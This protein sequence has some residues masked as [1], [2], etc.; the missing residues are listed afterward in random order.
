MDINSL[1]IGE[2]K[3]LAALFGNS[4]TKQEV[5]LYARYVGKYVICRSRNEGV[6]AGTV[7]AADETGVI[8]K[9]ARRLYY[10][11]PVNKNVSWYE[12]VANFG[13]DSSSKVGSAV[14]KVIVED[15]SLTVCSEEAEKSIRGAKEHAQ[16]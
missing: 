1:T 12:G 4:N 11:K 6:N 8:L 10:H 15:Y 9:D 14:E 2:A 7:L 13:L 3:Q 16:S 5:G